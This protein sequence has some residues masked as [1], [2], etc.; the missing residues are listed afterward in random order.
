MPLALALALA[1]SV[2]LVWFS[3]RWRK[4]YKRGPLEALMRRVTD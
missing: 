3:H 4:K 2:L 1:F